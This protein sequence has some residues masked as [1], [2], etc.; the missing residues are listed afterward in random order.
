M[1]AFAD[2]L[3]NLINQ[4]WHVNSLETWQRF[5]TLRDWILNY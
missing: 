4:R 1:R 2:S 3:T 5:T